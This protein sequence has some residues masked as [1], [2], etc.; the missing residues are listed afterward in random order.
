MWSMMKYQRS[1][2]ISL[3]KQGSITYKEEKE[4]LEYLSLKRKDLQ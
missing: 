2:I 3:I 4:K 1:R